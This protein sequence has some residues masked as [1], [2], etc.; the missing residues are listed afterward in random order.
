[1]SKARAQE[2]IDF[3]DRLFSDKANLDSLNQEIAEN[4]YPTR[5]CFTRD[6]NLGDNYADDLMDSYPILARRE[7]GNAMSAVQ[8][9][10]AKPW[11]GATTQDEILDNDPGVSRFLEYITDTVR[12]GLYDPR[13]KMIGVTKE[14][15]HDY[16]S[17]GQACMTL[18]ESPD[19]E[20]PRSHL[21]MDLHH[22]AHVAWKEN[23]I[24]TI[25]H[26][27]AKDTMTPWQMC[28]DF[29]HSNLAEPVKRAIDKEPNKHFNLRRIVMSAYEYDYIT[30][31]A[32][33]AKSKKERKL[34]F[35]VVY[36]DADNCKVLREG[37]LKHLPYVIPRWHRLNRT[38]YAFS[39]AAMT[40]LPD[41]RMMQQLARI[42]L[43]A[44]EKM[45]DPPMI[46][47]GEAVRDANIQAGSI[48]W[49]DIEG[50]GNVRDYFAQMEVKGNMTVGFELR[51]DVREM[52]Q[53]SWFLDRL[54]L[55]EAGTQMT[56]YETAQRVEQHVRNLLPLFEPMEVEYGNQLLDKAFYTLDN[57]K[58]FDWSLIPD[59][60]K[61]RDIFWT[62]KNPMQ[63]ASERVLVSQFGEV[64]QL[65]KAAQEFG[66]SASPFKLEVGLKDAIRGTSAPATWRK[67]EE[68]EEA[69]AKQAEVKAKIAGAAQELAAA[70]QVAEQVGK[71]AQQL[72][73]AGVLP[74]S[75]AQRAEA[76]M[77][78]P[79]QQGGGLPSPQLAPRQQSSSLPTLQPPP[80]NPYQTAA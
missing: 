22:L 59:M 42:I 47:H 38:P 30:P 72:Q 14:A 70:G 73:Q 20:N 46:A 10:K 60:L 40:S 67:T 18:E 25:D 51:K 12:N 52:M 5:A 1:M 53:K 36:V 58:A 39:P 19:R 78:M 41:A 6:I 21:Y 32:K 33:A 34:P 66:L 17:F 71:G 43:E 45:V 35:V 15:D 44:G 11:F 79:P 65:V 77:P 75:P 29:G 69:E 56:A 61:G 80:L 31:R 9:P 50:D 28:Q 55:P 68:E 26:V 2:L 16:V 74:M 63:E 76:G 48:T 7:L 54:Q 4:V 57:M 37:G 23:R 24:R 49:V 64:L 3:G 62:F 13:T 8:R 27:H